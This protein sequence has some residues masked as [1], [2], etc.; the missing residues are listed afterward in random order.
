M[1]DSI[2]ILVIEDSRT[3]A[4]RLQLVL[5][6][7]SY[8]ITLASN[9]REGLEYLKKKPFPIVITD[10]VMPE[11]DGSEF[12]KEVRQRDFTGYVFIIILTAKDSKDDI[13]IGLNAGADDYLVKPVDPRELIARL[14]TAERIIALEQTLNNRNQEVAL[15]SVTDSLTQAFNRRYLNE[16]LP[17]AIKRERRNGHPLSIILC[18][19]DHFKAVNDCYGHQA[20]DSVLESFAY[21]LKNTTRE[22]IDWIVRFGGEEFLIVLPETDFVG[23]E[24]AAER[25]RLLVSSQVIVQN[26]EMRKITA[27]F[28]FVSTKLGD[29]KSKI[30]MDTLIKAADKCLYQAK[31]EGRNR[32]CGVLL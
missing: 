8:H 9:G 3:Q 4:L 25:Y 16:K 15:L 10:W 22:G 29:D 26:S 28:G 30:D 11:M 14:K 17:F 1:S 5:E 24:K 12:C 6:Q 21:C 31:D 20:G 19:I 2:D 7:Y 27:S 13:I 32:V 23:A 18:D